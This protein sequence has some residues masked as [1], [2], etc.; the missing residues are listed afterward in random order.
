MTPADIAAAL[1][2]ERFAV[3]NALTRLQ[4]R[5]LVRVAGMVARRSPHWG[6]DRPAGIWEAAPTE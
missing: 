3:R 6:G 1:S 4:K 5:R 2:L